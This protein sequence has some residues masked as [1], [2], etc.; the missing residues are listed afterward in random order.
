M[1]TTADPV[2]AGLVDS[3]ARPGGNI[4]GLT[5]LVRELTGKQLELLK[6]V[7]PAAS[8][9]GFLLDADSTPAT[10]RFHEY[11]AVARIESGTC[12]AIS[13]TK[14]AGLQSRI[15]GRREGAVGRIDYRKK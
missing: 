2:A 7:L 6:E 1:M 10:A 14:K 5:L 11:E 15:H 12:L 13:G 8:R 9:L 4:T 3:L